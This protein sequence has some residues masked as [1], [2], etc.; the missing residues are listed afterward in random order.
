LK[1]IISLKL[2]TSI[3]GFGAYYAREHYV[4]P[5]PSPENM[6]VIGEPFRPRGAAYRLGAS[7]ISVLSKEP[8]LKPLK[9]SPASIVKHPPDLSLN[10]FPCGAKLYNRP[11]VNATNRSK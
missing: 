8:P 10:I 7:K 9:T 1:K 11:S 5:P 4:T 6:T 3:S 2:S